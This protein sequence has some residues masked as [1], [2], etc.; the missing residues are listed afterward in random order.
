[1]QIQRLSVN[2]FEESMDFLNLVF[3]QTYGPMDFEKMLPRLYKPTD[4]HMKHNLVVRDNGKIRALVGL[5]PSELVA[6]DSAMPAVLA[7]I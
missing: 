4:E 1:M 5:Y 3:S 7:G 2:D 6:G